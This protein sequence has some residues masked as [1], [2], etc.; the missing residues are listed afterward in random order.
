MKIWIVTPRYYPIDCGL[1]VVVDRLAS[2]MSDNSHEVTVLAPSAPPEEKKSFEVIQTSLNRL[3][4][5]KQLLSLRKPDI[6]NIHGYTNICFYSALVAFF[7]NIPCVYTLEGGECWRESRVS[8]KI[9]YLLNHSYSVVVT[10]DMKNRML[11]IGYRP[12]QF[13]TVILP[14]VD[15]NKFNADNY[16]RAREI[17][18][19]RFGIGKNEFVILIIGG[20]Y[21]I[22]EIKL[23][24]DTFLEVRKKRKCKLLLVGTGPMDNFVIK[25]CI[26]NNVEGD[27]IMPGNILNENMPIIYAGCD[28]FISGYSLVTIMEAMSS[29]KPVITCPEGGAGEIIDNGVDGIIVTDRKEGMVREVIRLIDNTSLGVKLGKKAIEKIIKKFTWDIITSKYL[30]VF[31]Q[32]FINRK[33][34]KCLK[35]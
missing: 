20:L 12:E 35:M 2:I 33:G 30:D 13:D 21:P 18:G 7:N 16:P 5:I 34:E 11:K 25:K 31:Q 27:V 9:I 10:E 26:D 22:K 4:M 1:S 32:L 24:T 14:G 28:V 23:L 15:K 8:K 3:G 17:L 29:G 19:K 6:I